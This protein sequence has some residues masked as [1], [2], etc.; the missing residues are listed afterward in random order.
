MSVEVI[1]DLD[2]II[3]MIIRADHSV[4]GIEFFTP[5][6]FSQQLAI[7]NRPQGYVISPPVHN[8]VKRDVLW[9]RNDRPLIS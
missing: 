5:D 4:E 6:V 1:R 8:P 7:M 2:Q 9:T 3:G